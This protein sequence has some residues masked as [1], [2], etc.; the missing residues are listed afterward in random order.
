MLFPVGIVG[1]TGINLL[2]VLLIGIADSQRLPALAAFDKPR[3]QADF[4]GLPGA[5]PV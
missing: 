5:L 2:R 3:K 1:L 4:P